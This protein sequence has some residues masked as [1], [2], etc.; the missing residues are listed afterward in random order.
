VDVKPKRTD[1]TM[2]MMIPRI[3]GHNGFG[4]GSGFVNTLGRAQGLGVG[5]FQALIN[6]DIYPG[7]ERD[8]LQSRRGSRIIKPVSAPSKWPAGTLYNVVPWDIGSNEYAIAQIGTKLYSQ[9]LTTIGNPTEILNFAGS[10]FN[11]GSGVAADLFVHADRL[12]VVHP[13]GNA[14]V[15]WFSGSSTFKARTMGMGYPYIG[16]VATP[17]SGLLTGRWIYGI[18]KVYRVNGADIL[19]S[20]PNRKLRTVG[21]LADTGTSN[22]VSMLL[23]VDAAE[24]DGDALWTH[25]R[26]WRSK[27]LNEDNT[28]PLYPID[29][30]GLPE[31]LYE[32]A[33]ITKAEIGAG[34]LAAV[35]TSASLPPGNAGVTAGKPGGV[36]TITDANTDSRLFNLI[37]LE[38]IELIPLPA[39]ECGCFHTDR[40]WVSGSTNDDVFYSNSEGTKYSEICDPL[41]FV[42]TGRDG[43]L[44]KRLISFERDLLVIKESKTGRILGGD[45]DQPFEVLDHRIGL[46]SRANAD[47]IPGFGVCAITNDFGYGDFK[48]FGLD[49]RWTTNLN[50]QDISKSVRPWVQ[51]LVDTPRFAYINGKII[52]SRDGGYCAVLH[53]KEGRGWTIYLFNPA[54][55]SQLIVFSGGTRAAYIGPSAYTLEIERDFRNVDDK[56]SDDTTDNAFI[57]TIMPHYFQGETGRETLEYEWYSVVGYLPNSLYGIP[58]SNG[59]QWPPASVDAVGTAFQIVPSSFPVTADKDGEYRLYLTP[60]AVGDFLWQRFQGFFLSLSM[61]TTAPASIRAQGMRV[62]LDAD[63]STF[64]S[65]SAQT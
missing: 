50:G 58:Y 26:L 52:I 42:H 27:S 17:G 55:H 35:A 12:F 65:R 64:L 47:Y 49:L 40:V 57:C 10:A 14:V 24:L 2:D 61:Y 5:E 60:Q 36:Y 29:A 23:T 28:D 44:V 43:T 7:A 18:E 30:Q 48:I 15:E 31:E 11:L 39:S 33:L 34:A 63:D 22:L 6:W 19:V 37:G 4:S 54:A 46:A 8:E 53:V 25:L 38:R 41:A 45:P 56:A 9:N 16:A 21:L 1:K 32:V 51:A 62:T 59:A 20:S 3:K 13:A